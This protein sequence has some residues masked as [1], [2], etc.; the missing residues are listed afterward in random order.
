MFNKMLVALITSVLQLGCK[1]RKKDSTWLTRHVVDRLNQWTIDLHDII[2]YGPS[3]STAD[4]MQK[5]VEDLLQRVVHLKKSLVKVQNKMVDGTVE[6]YMW[7]R[8][9]M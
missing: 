9:S 3:D 1:A 8:Q 7:I 2:H 4:N 5:K 6:V